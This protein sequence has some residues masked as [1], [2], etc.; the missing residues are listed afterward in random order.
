M[1]MTP[2]RQPV[3][4]VIFSNIRS[5]LLLHRHHYV[6]NW[7]AE[8]GPTTWV[9]TL[10]LRNL[11]RVDLG[12]I[13][14]ERAGQSTPSLRP[15][16]TVVKPGTIPLHG[17][18]IVYRLN[19]TLLERR[20]RSL[21]PSEA[22]AWVYL[23]HPSILRVLDNRKWQRVVYDM[24][25]DIEDTLRVAP[26]VVAAERELL[27]RA[28]IVFASSTALVEK[29]RRLGAKTCYVPNGVD[30]SRF[31]EAPAWSGR[32]R[33]VTYVGSVFEWFDEELVAQVAAERSDLSFRIVG[34]IRR[35]LSR[36]KHLPN[37]ELAGPVDAEAIPSEL[38]RCDLCIIPFR[39]GPLIRATDP[40]KLYE[41]L[42]A[43]RPVLATDLPQA[44]RFA[45]AVRVETDLA[46]WLRAIDELDTGKW[47][48]DPD[49]ARRRVRSADDWRR[50]F[51]DMQRAL[52]GHMT[53]A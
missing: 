48:F 29:S 46:G 10:G 51:D 28:D 44:Q 30:A 18:E 1:P 52:D 41:A 38:Y 15:D 40:L 27:R 36:L 20:L 4:T 8:L 14:G 24:C 12:R 35:P 49:E 13:L 9:D 37:V 25:D 16:V 26:R 47:D 11:R 23:P 39:P 3:C 2:A 33:D 21:A 31:A 45:P 6:A 42:A 34:P 22:V 53:H 32:V 43:G 19:G 50:R 5:D 17:V 7:R